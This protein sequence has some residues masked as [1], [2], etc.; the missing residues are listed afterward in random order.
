[1]TGR[2]GH[3]EKPI[4]VER[5]RQPRTVVEHTHKQP[6]WPL[7][8]LSIAVVVL[9]AAVVALT[10]AVVNL[11][12]FRD[13]QADRIQQNVTDAVC[14]V[15]DVLAAGGRLDEIRQQYRCGP[16]ASSLQE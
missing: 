11:A 13:Q 4:V 12:E 7:L 6:R 8:L 1:V 14:D 16:G 9:T 3:Y 15:L 2:E 5:R 10:L